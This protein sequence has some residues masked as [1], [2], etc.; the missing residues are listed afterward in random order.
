MK[1]WRSCGSQSRGQQGAFRGTPIGP[2]WSMRR[3][4]NDAELPR[5]AGPWRARAAF[6][7]ATPA[8]G[9]ALEVDAASLRC[10]TFLNNMYLHMGK[11]K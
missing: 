11:G 8:P 5:P 6:R 1:W 9:S 10:R 2:A 7:I 4:G 3:G